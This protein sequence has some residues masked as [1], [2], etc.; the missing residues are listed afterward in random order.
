[1]RPDVYKR[2]IQERRQELVIGKLL[3]RLALDKEN[4]TAISAGNAH[5]CLPGFPGTVDDTAHDRHGDGLLTVPQRLV[6]LLHQTNE[7]DGGCLLY[8]SRCV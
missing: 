6:H 5:V 1:M 4:A 3:H 8:T 7:V 2:Q